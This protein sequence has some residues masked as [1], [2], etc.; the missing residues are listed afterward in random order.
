MS[1]ENRGGAREGAG[2]KPGPQ[3]HLRRPVESL[4]RNRVMLNVT[5]RDLDKLLRQHK[6]SGVPI[7]TLL[8]VM[9]KQGGL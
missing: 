7:A 6:S 5:D 2:R 9:A 4:R 8:Y 3:P 1:P